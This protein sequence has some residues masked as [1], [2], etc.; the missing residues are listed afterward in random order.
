MSQSPAPSITPGYQTP[1]QKASRYRWW[2][3]VLLF[4]ATTINYLDRSILNVV[5]PTIRAE[6]HWTDYQFG[7]INASFS[8]AYALGFIIMGKLIDS[9][10]VKITYAFALA[11]W[12]LAAAAHA[13]AGGAVSFGIARFFLGLGEAGNF[14]AAIKTVAEW[15]PQKER[16]TATGIFNAGSNVGAILAPLVVP[17]IVIWMHWQAAFVLTGLV[18]L[19]WVFFWLPMYKSPA[20]HPKVNQAERDLILGGDGAAAAAVNTNEPPVKWRNLL[21]HRQ[22]WAFMV[23]KFMTDPVWW[24][25][26]TFAGIFFADKF[27]VSIKTI[28]IPLIII[29]VLADF[30]SIIG[31]WLSSTLIHRGWTANAA[32]KTAMFTCAICV[33]PVIYAPIT[34]SMIF[35]AILIGIAAA[36][37]QGFSANI[38]T[39]TSDMFPKKAVGSVVGLGGFT[40]AI[41]GM[42]MATVA[43]LIKE[44]TG[45]FVIMF[46]G[47]G[48]V[49]VFAVLVVHLLVPSLNRVTGEELQNTRIP[50]PV[51]C[52][53][54]AII[55]C[56]AGVPLSYTFQDHN[57]PSARSFPVYMSDVITGDIFKITVPKPAASAPASATAPSAATA[58]AAAGTIEIPTT[59]AATATSAATAAPKP[60]PLPESEQRANRKKISGPLVYTPLGLAAVMALLGALVH[61]VLLRRPQKT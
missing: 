13:L 47:A 57:L 16:A 50:V 28:G 40:G 55:G 35:S 38:F 26:N 39:L 10:G 36:A 19:V 12:S 5:A 49:Y 8:L 15:F 45:D 29:Y 61:G 37:H 52:V 14:P 32:R 43:G 1:G 9:L 3:C 27:G 7:L 54:W 44:V 42:I 21:P 33:L 17:W 58:P 23:G 30:G 4:F 59:A 56:L 25:Y 20:E 6:Q 31:G 41:G 51:W 48:V 18:G 53:V 22:A 46:I 60:P 24:F 34:N 11:F 2:I